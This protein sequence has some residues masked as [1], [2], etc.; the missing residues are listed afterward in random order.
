MARREEKAEAER[1]KERGKA[2]EAE[3]EKRRGNVERNGES[4]GKKHRGL[5]KRRKRKRKEEGR[6]R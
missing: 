4:T 2:E 5:R 3:R 1:E 6:S